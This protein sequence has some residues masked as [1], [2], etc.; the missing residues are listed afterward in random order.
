MGKNTFAELAETLHGTQHLY[1]LIHNGP[2]PDCMGAAMGL[3]QLLQTAEICRSTIVGGGY[4]QRPDNRA[5]VDMLNIEIKRPE[6]I[7]IPADAPFLCVDTQPGFSNNSLPEDAH[8]LGVIDHHIS[9]SS[10]HAP[11][12]DIRPEYG[13]CASIIAEYFTES[14]TLMHKRIATALSFAIATETRDM[15][16]V[17]KKAE[18]DIYTWLLA[19]ADHPVLGRLRNPKIERDYV[20][21]LSQALQTAEFYPPDIAVCHLPELPRTDD[22]GR[23]ADFL[24]QMEVVKWTLC[25][26][27][28]DVGFL[29]SMRSSKKD[30]K[31]E[32]IAKKVIRDEGDFGGH[33]MMAGGIIR[34]KTGKEETPQKMAGELTR[35]FLKAI[36]RSSEK[37][38]EPLLP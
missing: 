12:L 13:A 24:D 14:Q 15:E 4:V 38:V 6:D 28:K 1:I 30:A 22:L 35:R 21:I 32:E 23:I 9:N 34:Q 27:N 20:R 17:K 33:G 3:Q 19:K 11:F 29:L 2:D 16:R 25:T 37:P 7:E 5:M 36:G 10:S 8:V 31:C 18:V 26:E